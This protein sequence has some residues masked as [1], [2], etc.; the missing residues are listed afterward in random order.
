MVEH[1]GKDEAAYLNI[2]LMPVWVHEA[3]VPPPKGC[4]PYEADGDKHAQLRHI[5]KDIRLLS[6][7]EA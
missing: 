6:V 7:V 1:H 5:A 3:D 4:Q 2:G